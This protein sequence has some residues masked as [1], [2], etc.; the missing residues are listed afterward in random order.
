MAIDGKEFIKGDNKRVLQM[1]WSKLMNQ[2]Q[3]VADIHE[4]IAGKE[5]NFRETAQIAVKAL[6]VNYK[7]GVDLD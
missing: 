6:A 1:E 3:R 5:T 2:V 4:K 7:L